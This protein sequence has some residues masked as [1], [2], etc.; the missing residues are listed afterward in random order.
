MDV[1]SLNSSRENKKRYI[2][3]SN[4]D[5]KKWS[6]PMHQLDAGLE[7]YE[8]SSRRGHLLKQFLPL[9][10]RTKI[11]PGVL[12]ASF[13]DLF[14][15]RKLTELIDWYFGTGWQCSVFWGTPC[16]DQKITL[17]IY[18]GEKIL[19]YCKIGNSDRVKELFLHEKKILDLLE[20]RR[21]RHV[22]RCLAVRQILGEFWILIQTTEKK[23]G[24]EE[25]HQYH[26]RQNAFLERLYEGTKSKLLFERTDYCA[27]L[28]FLEQNLR[29]VPQEYRRSTSE[30]LKEV[31]NIYKGQTVEWGV[32]HRDFTP[33]NTCIS[34]G[35]LF[36]FDFEYALLQAP[37][38]LDRWHFFVQTKIFEEKCDE[39][40]LLNAYWEL[41][42]RVQ[43]EEQFIC[44][45][46]DIISLYLQRGKEEDLRTVRQ[47]AELLHEIRAGDTASSL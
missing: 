11:L 16:V 10:A 40:E 17:Q 7:I 26:E 27:S 38:G 6:I 13:T 41:P 45:L 30:A 5:G 29:R 23:K 1:L 21:I 24:S 46:L 35:Q 9:F 33:W 39:T 2:T 12:H 4:Q 31:Y 20:Q 36:V 25:E 14:V 44:Y 34:D 42:D 28:N 43:S 37:K 18:I 19:G 32:C 47:R 3:F 8:P 15:H 22:P